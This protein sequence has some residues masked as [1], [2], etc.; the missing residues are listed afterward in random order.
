MRWVQSNTTFIKSTLIALALERRFKWQLDH[1]GWH[2]LIGWAF[3]HKKINNC[4]ILGNTVVYCCDSIQVYTITKMLYFACHMF[5]FYTTVLQI[6]EKSKAKALYFE[7]KCA[8]MLSISPLPKH[9][10]GFCII[11]TPME[12]FESYFQISF[13]YFYEMYFE[14]LSWFVFWSFLANSSLFNSKLSC[15]RSCPYK[16]ILW[17]N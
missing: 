17:G 8:V 11:D 1:I 9:G 13:F 15:R 2:S 5:C 12:L 4:T 14:C 10:R 7:T 3:W 16:C 6:I